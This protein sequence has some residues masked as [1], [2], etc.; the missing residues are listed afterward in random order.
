[1]A[2][3]AYVTASD[4]KL[5]TNKAEP[6][7]DQIDEIFKNPFKVQKKKPQTTQEIYDYVLGLLPD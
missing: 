2:N 3:M 7:S 6:F 5:D 1:M 4:R